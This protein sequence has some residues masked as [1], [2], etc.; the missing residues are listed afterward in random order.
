V[1]VDSG[2][3]SWYITNNDAV[4]TVKFY[5]GVS[6]NYLWGCTVLPKFTECPLPILDSRK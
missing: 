2:N 4:F 1:T 6:M 5:A 3:F